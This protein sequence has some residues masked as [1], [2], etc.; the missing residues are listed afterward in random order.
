MD[1]TNTAIVANQAELTKLAKKEASAAIARR[2]PSKGTVVKVAPATTSDSQP[3]KAKTAQAKIDAKVAAAAQAAIE[4]TAKSPKGKVAKADGEAGNGVF[5]ALAGALGKEEKEQAKVAAKKAIDKAKAAPAKATGVSTAA[6]LAERFHLGAY[7]GKSGAMYAFVM[8]CGTLGDTFSR[9]E[10]IA[11]FAAKQAHEML[12]TRAQVLDYFAWAARH[13]LLI[14]AADQ[15]VPAANVNSV[16]GKTA[17]ARA[18]K[19]KATA[20]VATKT[21]KKAAKA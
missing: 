7:N 8:R 9:E 2:K 17:P 6:K 1:T 12:A 21:A 16:T 14:R 18:T 10:A 4:K 15:S 11:S 13:G 3:T 20:K 19:P 5:N